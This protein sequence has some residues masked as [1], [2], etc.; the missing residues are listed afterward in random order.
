MTAPRSGSILTTYRRHKELLLLLLPSMVLLVLFN[1]VPMVGL[2]LA[3]KDYMASLGMVRSPWVG[4]ENFQRLFASEDFPRALRNT[5]TISLL[6]LTFGFVA[7]IVLALMLNE[8]RVSWFKRGVQ[9]LT[10]LPYFLSWVILGG[11]FLMLLGSEGPVNWLV[12]AA[13]HS[14]V[15]FLSNGAWFIVTII[16]TGIWQSAGYGAVIYLAALAGIDPN[17]YEAAAIDGAGR[18]KQTRH[19]TLPC[20]APTIVVLLI[21]SLSNILNAGFDQIYNM[22]NP[23]VYDV[24]D[25]ID[26]YVLRRMVYQDF[27]LATAAGL[28]K[29]VIG[30]LLVVSANGAARRL[31]GGEHG[32]W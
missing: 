17:L 3:F 22:F 29:S 30:L 26:T 21:L 28:F 19:V 16:L 11:M 14:P 6:R 5:A 2:V 32:I 15:S 4:L 27:G 12:Q 1:Y 8:V 20:L 7:P 13:G 23:M 25:I 18:W 24:G 31:S 9:T 10:Y